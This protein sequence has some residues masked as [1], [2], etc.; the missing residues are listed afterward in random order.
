MLTLHL[1]R[2]A[3]PLKGLAYA[4]TLTLLDES[5]KE[6]EVQSLRWMFRDLVKLSI[7]KENFC[8]LSHVFPPFSQSV[9]NAGS[10]QVN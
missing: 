9:R 1:A 8:H 5:E 2:A 4:Y 7:F 10:Q 6:N 3:N